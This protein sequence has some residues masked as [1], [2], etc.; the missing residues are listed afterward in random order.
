MEEEH[1][2][3]CS[4]ADAQSG[5]DGWQVG[6]RKKQVRSKVKVESGAKV[7]VAARILLTA[8]LLATANRESE[9][10]KTTIHASVFVR[11]NRD[12]SEVYV[13]SLH[14]FATY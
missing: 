2:R 7:K 12:T 3:A 8:H 14:V 9:R 10:G 11:N 5:G 1:G 13:T 4:S 6:E